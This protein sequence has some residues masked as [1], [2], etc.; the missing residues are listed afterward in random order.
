MRTSRKSI[1][2]GETQGVVKL[3]PVD[4]LEAK[5]V[6]KEVIEQLDKATRMLIVSKDARHYT[7]KENQKAAVGFLAALI[8]HRHYRE[9][10]VEAALNDP[11]KAM[12]HAIS[13]LPKEIMVENHTYLEKVEV[14]KPSAQSLSEWAAAVG[15]KPETQVIDVKP[16]PEEDTSF[17]PP[18][19]LDD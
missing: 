6:A 5:E 10:Y 2:P 11:M 14:F 12:A 4:K 16:E 9:R 13:T 8:N 3:E 18:V 17:K 19:K 7:P 1:E 15:A